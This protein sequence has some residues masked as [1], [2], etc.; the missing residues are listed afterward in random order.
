M[1]SDALKPQL[2]VHLLQL[3]LPLRCLLSRL[4]SLCRCLSL[5]L[6]PLLPPALLALLSL[7]P[8]PL[9][10]ALAALLLL[11]RF[12]RRLRQGLLSLRGA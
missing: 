9:P 10:L 6:L 4:E 12:R 11:L 1:E 3:R 2:R 7:V 8:L 5:L